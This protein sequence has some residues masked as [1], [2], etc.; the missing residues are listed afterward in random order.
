MTGSGK[1]SASH[2]NTVEAPTSAVA[3]TSNCLTRMLGKTG[4]QRDEMRSRR[5]SRS[6]SPGQN[7]DSRLSFQLLLTQ[8]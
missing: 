8:R 1:P 7:S 5:S 3:L 6:V 4:T 2:A